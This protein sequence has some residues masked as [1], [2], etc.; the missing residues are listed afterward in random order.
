MHDYVSLPPTPHSC[1]STCVWTSTWRSPRRCHWSC[2]SLGPADPETSCLPG[3]WFECQTAS[4]W[5][6]RKGRNPGRAGCCCRCWLRTWCP[7]G[8]CFLPPDH[9]AASCASSGPTLK[10]RT[11]GTFKS[12]PGARNHDF[13]RS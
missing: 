13:P 2:P 1:C 3:T 12:A 7:L 6:P 10:K 11:Q 4:R 8:F 9:R 5:C